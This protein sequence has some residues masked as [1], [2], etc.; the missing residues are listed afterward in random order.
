MAT[1]IVVV[2]A[3]A[4]VVPRCRLIA[5][6]TLSAP[7]EPGDRDPQQER[8]H[9]GHREDRRDG[10]TVAEEPGAHVEGEHATIQPDRRG[11]VDQ[12]TGTYAAGS[13]SKR[14]RHPAAQK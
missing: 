7:T 3:W 14:A 1:V 9:D 5:A 11:T 2:S 6:V 10:E 12:P 13:A 4:S 8:E